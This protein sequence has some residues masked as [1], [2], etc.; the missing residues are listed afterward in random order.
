MGER[1]IFPHVGRRTL[2]NLPGVQRQVYPCITGTFGGVDFLHSVMGEFSDKATQSEI[3]ELE[4]TMTEGSNG[5]TSLLKELLSSVPAGLF[6]NK[7]QAG[8][9]DELQQ[10][11]TAA[12]M[13]NMHV[14]PHQPEA[15]TRQ[16]QATAKEI[17]P[18]IQWH[19]EI[20][21]QITEAIEKIPILPALI[22]Q[23]EEQIN[24]F[25]FSLLAPFVL[26]IINQIKTELNTGSSEIIQS[27]KD[28]QLIV[29]NDDHSSDP[30]HSMLSKDHFS[31]IL[32]EPAGK[33]ASQVLKW[34]IPQVIQCMDDERVDVDRTINRI[35]NGVF[36]HPAQRTM[37]DDGAVDGR[38]LMFGV[39]E[40][41]WRE[42]SQYEQQEL[43]RQLSRDGIMNG[44]NHKESV[45]D[46]GHGC[47]KPLGMAKSGAAAGASAGPARALMGGLSSALSGG[48]S[49]SGFGGSSNANSGIGSFASEAVGGGA[50]GGLV[51][52]LA[53]GVGGS[54][55]SGAFGGSSPPKEIKTYANQGYTP[56]GGFQQSYTEV[57][58]G[59]GNQYAQAQYTETQLPGGGRQT[60][61]QRFQQTG[62]SGAGFEQRTQVQPTYG[63]GYEQTNE[64]IYQRPGGEVETETWREGRTADGRQYHQ[65]QPQR[66][67][68]RSDDDSDGSR[69]KHGKH[70]KKKHHGSGSDNDEPKPYEAPGG[71]S[72]PQKERFEERRNEYNEPPRQEYGRQQEYGGFQEHPPPTREEYGGRGGFGG[73]FEERPPP[74][75]EEYGGR[76]EYGGGREQ[77]EYGGGR[78]GFGGNEGGW[79]QRE[80]QEEP[81]EER[82]EEYREERRE[83]RREEGGGGW[84]N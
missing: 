26:P 57:A 46:S 20:M 78:G 83:E 30:T 72:A 47:G 65:S 45:H 34:V 74:R 15:F 64:R 10:N 25:V 18:I 32:N 9:A 24:I 1:D 12:Q 62:S 39:V 44:E 75:R 48:A 61:F 42:K 41:W 70:H 22:E 69:K 60:D 19:D 38:K 17:Y 6:G 2:I 66:H 79:G 50:L 54:F 73:G 35:I 5:D 4:G 8:K 43:R 84:F 11:A 33:I 28:K 14:S 31:N 55:L 27:S 67:E 51:G 13:S 56:Q 49:S 76:Q 3:Q 36:H 80:Q 37:G 23:I 40:G 82:E 71:Y 16:M 21:L 68:E 81:E 77:E 53:G 7:D 29:F 52:A 63:G 59:G 58:H